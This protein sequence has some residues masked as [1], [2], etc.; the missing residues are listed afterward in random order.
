MAAY[1]AEVDEAQRR[2]AELVAENQQLRAQH[3][4][5]KIQRQM[6]YINFKT[7]THEIEDLKY[8]C[9][10]KKII[11]TINIPQSLPNIP[12]KTT[13]HRSSSISYLSSY[14]FPKAFR[15]TLPTPHATS[16]SLLPTILYTTFFCPI[17]G[18]TSPPTALIQRRPP[19]ARFCRPLCPA[20]HPVPSGPIP[21][22]SIPS[23]PAAL[24]PSPPGPAPASLPCASS[25]PPSSH[26]VPLPPL[27]P[28]HPSP[29]SGSG[30]NAHPTNL[31]HAVPPAVLSPQPPCPANP[32]P[33]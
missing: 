4:Q 14:Q 6:L 29:Q 10:I 9:F 22:P 24:F 21:A 30:A 15:L 19:V 23:L 32:H 17:T 2:M 26:P 3:I 28:S 5:H 12:T 18:Q 20:S 8:Q 16:S 33:L 7:L 1:D 11:T 13:P 27:S 31:L 25:P